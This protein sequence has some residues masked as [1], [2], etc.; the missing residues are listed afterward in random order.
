MAK[1]AAAPQV[2]D[3]DE[4][5]AV[6]NEDLVGVSGVLLQSF[7]HL[8][9]PPVAGVLG[10]PGRGKHCEP[11]LLPPTGQDGACGTV[12]HRVQVPAW[13]DRR[14]REAMRTRGQRYIETYIS[15]ISIH[16]RRRLHYYEERQGSGFQ[17]S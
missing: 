6:A 14:E 11:T 7:H 13:E 5:A 3:N 10:Q 15:C 4:A 17:K 1:H 9:H 16:K 12:A 8:K 2:P